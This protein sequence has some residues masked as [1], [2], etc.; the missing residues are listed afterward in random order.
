[1]RRA[2][3]IGAVLAAVVII[4]SACGTSESSS[5]QGSSV[6]TTSE[7][8]VPIPVDLQPYFEPAPA[9]CLPAPVW[10]GGDRDRQAILVCELG[11]RMRDDVSGVPSVRPSA[12]G[13]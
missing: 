6:T 8:P 12:G 11:W 9:V 4:V 5:T 3:L 10:D 13:R 2:L 1:V 7:Y